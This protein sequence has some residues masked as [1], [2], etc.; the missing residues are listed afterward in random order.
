MMTIQAQV[1][2][3]SRS[4]STKVGDFT[5]FARIAPSRGL[6]YEVVERIRSDIGSGRLRPGDRLPTEQD[7]I[8]SLGV[9]RTVVREAVAALRAEGLV[10]TRQGVGAFVADD[11]RLRPFR[12]APGGLRSIAEVLQVMELRTG[13]ETEAA[14]LAAE[15]ATAANIE[16]IEAALETFDRA[17]GGGDLAV[18]EDFAFHRG[19]AAA[20]G[21]PHFSSFLEFLGRFIIPRQSV[22]IAMP[23]PRGYLAAIQAEHRQILAAIR[24][25]S[26]A[27]AQ[28]AMRRHLS[29]SR[30]RYSRL[31]GSDQD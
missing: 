5:G 10:I 30:E 15:R 26:A 19:I 17:I 4:A 14:G 8:A 11:M 24:A 31:V 20:T 22:R 2:S 6:A 9:S 1:P 12:I 13:V 18:A 21:N 29:N 27:K 25:R 28:A 23:D 7:M 16:A 3:V